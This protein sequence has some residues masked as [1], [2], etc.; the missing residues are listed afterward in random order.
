MGVDEIYRGKKGK[1][2][3]VVCNLETG[4][5]LWSAELHRAVRQPG[6]RLV[7]LPGIQSVA[8]TQTPLLTEDDDLSSIVVPGREPKENESAPNVA[9]VSPG[10]FAALGMPVLSGREFT[11]ADAGKA[12]KVA[13]VN[14]TFAQTFFKSANPVGRSFYVTARPPSPSSAWRRTESMATCARPSS[15]SSSAPTRIST[16]PAKAA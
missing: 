3:T 2:L 13:V 12:P 8:A 6:Q 4:E 15:H 5:P 16:I 11:E 7:T 10:F 14:E 1:F 9:A